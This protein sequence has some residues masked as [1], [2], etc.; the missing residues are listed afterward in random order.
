MRPLGVTGPTGTKE[1][2]FRLK[3]KL[4][5]GSDRTQRYETK[6]G[7]LG[8]KTR[9][10]DKIN[11]D[12]ARKASATAEKIPEYD[13]TLKWYAD[14]LGHQSRAVALGG[15]GED[16]NNLKAIAAA[17]TAAKQLRDLSDYEDRIAELEAKTAHVDELEKY[18]AGT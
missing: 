10:L 9:L 3:V 11:A 1:N 17:A 14:V 15:D 16:R 7:A 4:E 5:D 18:G 6:Q 12:K 13:G 2:G 8:A